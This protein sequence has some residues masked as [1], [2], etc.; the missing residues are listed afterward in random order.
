M[1]VV[2]NQQRKWWFGEDNIKMEYNRKTVVRRPPPFLQSNYDRSR[3]NNNGFFPHSVFSYK[4]HEY[5]QGHHF[6]N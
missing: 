1:Y 2:A 4:E 6:Q 3:Y 5:M